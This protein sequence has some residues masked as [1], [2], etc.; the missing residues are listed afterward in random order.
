MAGR[1]VGTQGDPI[2][3]ALVVSR[4]QRGGLEQVL[5]D[6][7]QGLTP[8][9]FRFEVVA[10]HGAGERDGDFEAAGIAVTHLAGRPRIASVVANFVCWAKLL[11]VLHRIRP[12]VVQTHLFFGGTLGRIAARAAGVPVVVQADHNFYA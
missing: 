9:G 1:S 12:H 11:G 7:A 2:R 6:V 10:L 3:V 8:R 4:L 5:L